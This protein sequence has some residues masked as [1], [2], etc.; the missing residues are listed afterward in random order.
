MSVNF[1]NIEDRRDYLSIDKMTAI[2][3]HGEILHV[4]DSVKHESQ[5]DE[6][7]VI[8]YFKLNIK[9]N[10]IEAM[11]TKGKAKISFIYK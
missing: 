4:G 6:I 5:G 9:S 10:D 7:A 3:S 11:T 2:S 8:K 1:K